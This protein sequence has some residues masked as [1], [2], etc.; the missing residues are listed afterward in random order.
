VKKVGF[1]VN[2]LAGIGGRV[3]LKG[4]DG[5]EIVRRAFAL[6]AKPLSPIRSAEALTRLEDIKDQF[7]LVTY[8]HE[9]GEDEARERGFDPTVIGS[10][11]P[12]NTSAED[13]KRAAKDMVDAGV[14]L[15]I[16]AGGDG[17]A[18]DMYDAIGNVIPV[19]G[20]PA[21]C[22]I[23]SAIYAATPLDAG[24]LA[25]LF[26]KDQIL[27]TAELEVMDIDEEAFREEEV[28]KARLYGYLRVPDDRR[29]TQGAKSGGGP[30]EAFVARRIAQ[31]VVEEMQPDHYY[32]IGSGTTTRYIMD[33]LE[34]P[35]SLLG[36]D[37]VNNKKLV[38]K[39][40]TEKE[41]LGILD[42]KPA[43]IVVT[44]IGGQGY[45]FGRGNQQLSPDVIKKVGRDNIKV[46]ATGDKLAT[47][48]TVTDKKL[49]VDTGDEEVNKMLRGYMK[50]ISA[51]GESTLIKVV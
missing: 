11:E 23:H 39:D 43:T 32:I 4:S 24:E 33:E 13:T 17:T 22:K 47:L 40:V 28:V 19:V 44:V 51:Y 15:I 38:A 35:N 34:L 42:H 29:F 36:V 46:I 1:I 16:F 45:I 49:R 2:P 5:A 21:G 41:L 48:G 6:G 9:M 7:E 25:A 30:S 37:V 3:A 10:I 12:G 14:D 8:P 18:R 27:R 26:I 50:V 31:R 20:I